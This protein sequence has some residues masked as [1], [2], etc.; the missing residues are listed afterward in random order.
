MVESVGQYLWRDLAGVNGQVWERKVGSVF[1]VALCSWNHFAGSDTSSTV[2]SC[3]LH[4]TV[5]YSGTAQP[6]Y[7]N[8]NEK[9]ISPHPDQTVAAGVALCA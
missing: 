5:A 6:F 3:L 4:F 1:P 8:P 2:A 9:G 7:S